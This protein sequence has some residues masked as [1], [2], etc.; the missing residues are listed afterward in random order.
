MGMSTPVMGVPAAPRCGRCTRPRPRG[1]SDSTA[2]G[3]VLASRHCSMPTRRLRD[4]SPVAV[5]TRSPRPAQA[6]ERLLPARPA[7]GPAASSR[8]GRACDQGGACVH[9]QLPCPSHRPVA[10]AS[11]FFTA[12]PTSTP[13]MS[14]LAY[15]RN[16]GAVEGGHQR[17]PH[18]WRDRLPPPSA[19]GWS[20]SNFLR[21][22]GPAQAHPNARSGAT[23][24]LHTS[25]PSKPCI[26]GLCAGARFE[27]LCTARPRAC[28][29]GRA[30]AASMP[31]QPRHGR[32]HDDQV[33]T[34]WHA[35]QPIA[36]RRWACTLQAVA[37]KAMLLL[38]HGLEVDFGQMHRREAGALDQSA[39]LPRR[40]GYTIWGQAMPMIWLICSCS[41]ARISKIPACLTSTRKYGLFLELGVHGGG[42]TDLV[43]A[44]GG[45]VGFHAELDVDRGLFL[46]E[47][48]GRGIGLLQR[49]FLEVNALNLEGRS[50]FVSH[51]SLSG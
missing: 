11:T 2:C 31:A 38:V 48:D 8:P 42:D 28:L 1:P 44:V 27:A 45:R 50:V 9:S 46:L 17:F 30:S 26:S 40:Y 41:I 49:R 37:A 20:R 7:P 43:D 19:V 35:V 18:I 12:P 24:V 25:W 13:T 14:S 33:G 5:S 16:A 3:R 15:T 23:C 34:E 22:T 10:I 36:A 32:G 4:R 21:K 6:H 39:T 47:Q 51:G 29:A